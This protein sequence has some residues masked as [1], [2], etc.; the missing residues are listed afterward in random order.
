MSAWSNFVW[1]TMKR[2]ALQNRTLTRD[3]AGEEPTA[4]KAVGLGNMLIGNTPLLDTDDAILFRNVCPTLLDENPP[5]SI[6]DQI[7]AT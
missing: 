3:K 5:Q 1:E 6:L 7:D 2:D 4:L